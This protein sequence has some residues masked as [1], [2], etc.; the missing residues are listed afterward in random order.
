[1]LKEIEI[2]F[3]TKTY[4]YINAKFDC[5]P[6]KEEYQEA[7]DFAEFHK[8]GTNKENG[9]ICLHENTDRIQSF[10]K[11]RDYLSCKDCG[12]I[13]DIFHDPET[14]KELY[15]WKGNIK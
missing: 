8:T 9:S 3:A 6:S 1:M 5:I 10:D 13:A 14:G 11:N 12:L 7:K 15:Q 2:R 4:E